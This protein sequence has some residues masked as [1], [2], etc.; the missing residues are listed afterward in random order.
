MAFT[1]PREQRLLFPG[2]SVCCSQGTAFAVPRE[3]LLLFPGNSL[4]CAQIKILLFPG[5][6]CCCSQGTVCAVPRSKFCCSQLG[7]LLFPENI[8]FAP[9]ASQKSFAG[10]RTHV[11]T[12][13]RLSLSQL[14]YSCPRLCPAPPSSGLEAARAHNRQHQL[15]KPLL[16]IPC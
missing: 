1:V 4:C 11:P 8:F 9:A 2:N 6:A 5:N 7:I 14:G 3:R 13:G 16:S 10:I 12:L 15:H